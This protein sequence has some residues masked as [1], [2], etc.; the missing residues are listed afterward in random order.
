MTMIILLCRQLDRKFK[1]NGQILAVLCVLLLI[2]NGSVGFNIQQGAS[3]KFH[4]TPVVSGW[5]K[6]TGS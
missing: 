4:L 3:D 2:Y 6:T 5:E 1:R